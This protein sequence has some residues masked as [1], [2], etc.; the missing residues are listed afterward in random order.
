MKFRWNIAPPQPLLAG[1]L[2]TSVGI[3]PLLAQCLLN[4]GLDKDDRGFATGS[5][6]YAF[7]AGFFL[8]PLV[9]GLLMPLGSYPLLFA[10]L[11][12]VMLAA[13]GAILA[14]RGRL[15]SA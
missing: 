12:A 4:R 8:G 13:I 11:T 9:G 2:A 10:T 7:S 5:H 14:L 1:S 6:S 15:E 3:T